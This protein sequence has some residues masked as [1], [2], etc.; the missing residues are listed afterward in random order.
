MKFDCDRMTTLA[1]RCRWALLPCA[2]CCLKTLSVCGAVVSI[3]MVQLVLMFCHVWEVL[4]Q[5]LTRTT[6]VQA[7]FLFFLTLSQVVTSTGSQ[8]LHFAYVPILHGHLIIGL[9]IYILMALFN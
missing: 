1:A 4:A 2:L 3:W 5:I 8:L 7:S 6:Y 9:Y